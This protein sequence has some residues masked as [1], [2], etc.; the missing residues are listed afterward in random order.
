MGLPSS[1]AQ[2]YVTVQFLLNSFRASAAHAHKAHRLWDRVEHPAGGLMDNASQS[3]ILA[4]GLNTLISKSHG[5]KYNQKVQG[6]GD[7]NRQSLGHACGFC[8]RRCTNLRPES[9][10]SPRGADKRPPTPRPKPG[11]NAPLNTTRT[12]RS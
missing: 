7:P 5:F 3:L 11:A 6:R 10:R 1:L 9:D 8:Q 12:A 2:L 4:W